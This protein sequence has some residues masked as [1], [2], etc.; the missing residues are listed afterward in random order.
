[1][2]D[3]QIWITSVDLDVGAS[4]WLALALEWSSGPEDKSQLR[5]A[6]K[7][8]GSPLIAWFAFAKCTQIIPR[9]C[10]P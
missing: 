8:T 5:K 9:N 1:M 2:Q 3:K 6:A 4:H 10:S 7:D